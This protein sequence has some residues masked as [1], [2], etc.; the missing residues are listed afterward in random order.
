M[1][2]GNSLNRVHTMSYN[3]ENFYLQQKRYLD[4]LKTAFLDVQ[5]KGSNI[6]SVI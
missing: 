6:Q 5:N 2:V 1:P 3:L 4:K